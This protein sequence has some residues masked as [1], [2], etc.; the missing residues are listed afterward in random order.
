MMI[1]LSSTMISRRDPGGGELLHT[2]AIFVSAA[3][4]GVKT[5]R[6]GH[7]AAS[8][9]TTVA[10]AERRFQDPVRERSVW[11]NPGELGGGPE[12]LVGAR[13]SREIFDN[14]GNG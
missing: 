13:K 1:V 6:S 7:K 12:K 9:G 11:G 4:Q 14:S 8:R 2:R 5:C 3:T 10:R